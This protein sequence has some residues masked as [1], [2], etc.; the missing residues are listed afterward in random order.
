VTA[1]LPT[2]SPP[3]VARARWRRPLAA[4]GALL[5]VGALGFVGG[6]LARERRVV[7]AVA[8]TTEDR[9]RD[10]RVDRWV[11]RDARG[12]LAN[13]RDDRDHD[14]VPDRTEIYVD[15]RLNRIDYDSDGD[16]R[17]DSTDQVNPE[18]VVVMIMTDRNWNTLPERWVQ[19]NARRQVA[20]EWID[21]NEDSTP[22]R[23]RS[24]DAA[25]RLTEEGVDDDGDGLYELNRTFNTRW[26]PTAGPLR[27]ERDDDR[28]GIFERRETYTQGGR[29][30]TVNDD[31]DGDSVRDRIA[32]YRPDGSVRKQG[33][34]R[35]GDGFFE[36]WRFPQAGAPA[37]VGYD[38]DEDYDID[39]WEA[40]GPPDGWCA[41]R[42]SGD[43]PA[44]LV[45]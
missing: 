43:A 25:G 18:G 16:G 7:P 35:D 29:L 28:D 36:L 30:R 1:P 2:P 22:E 42:C 9:N 10:G 24:F 5:A 21:A 20:S 45:R 23:Y 26:P 13:V 44:A 3:A 27:V 33:H 41:A 32:V 37:R 6:W 39:R 38:D 31:S 14:G 12:R 11:E 34:D 17:Y 8:V 15:G 4:I 40:P 19:L